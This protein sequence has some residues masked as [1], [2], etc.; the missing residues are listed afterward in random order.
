MLSSFKVLVV[1]GD[2]RRNTVGNWF[3]AGERPGFSNLLDGSASLSEVVF[4]CEG[5]SVHFIAGGTSN[6][7]PA[8]LLH[9]PQL[10]TNPRFDGA[11][12]FG[13][14]RFAPIDVDYG[15]AP[16]CRTNRSRS[17]GYA[18]LQNEEKVT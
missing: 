14:L 17:A 6:L 12:R 5:S 18:S 3:G 2:L 16:P 4:A 9:S 7:P 1:D 11:L 8:E 13:S 15:C 10:A